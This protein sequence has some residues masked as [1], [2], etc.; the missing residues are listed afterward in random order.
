MG[1][2]T[3]IKNIGSIRAVSSAIKYESKRQIEVLQAGGSITNETRAWDAAS[4]I[5]VAMR[6]KEDK[7][8]S[9]NYIFSCLQLTSIPDDGNVA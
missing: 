7:L 1:V 6:D 4:K 3:E 2:R 9:S 5:T 8:V